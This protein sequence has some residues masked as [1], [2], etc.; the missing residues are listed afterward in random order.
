MI[1]KFQ[2]ILSG[3]IKKNIGITVE[4]TKRNDVKSGEKDQIA[5]AILHYPPNKHQPSTNN[6]RIHFNSGEKI[7]FSIWFTRFQRIFFIKTQPSFS[8]LF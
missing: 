1:E 7:I 5:E 4:R 8:F 6:S 2:S 3:V